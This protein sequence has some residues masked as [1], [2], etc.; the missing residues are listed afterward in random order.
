MNPPVCEMKIHPSEIN[1]ISC[2]PNFLLSQFF[3]LIF[4][5]SEKNEKHSFPKM[6]LQFQFE[7]FRKMMDHFEELFT[8]LWQSFENFHFKETG[9]GFSIDQTTTTYFILNWW[10]NHSYFHIYKAL[11]SFG[12]P[13]RS[14][15]GA[16]RAPKF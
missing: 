12:H 1:L 13:Q 9:K 3:L 8:N 15:F 10:N 5:F 4:M 2:F 11:C 16:C 14:E 7:P 6:L